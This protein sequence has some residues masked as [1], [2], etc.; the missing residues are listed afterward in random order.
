MAGTVL[1]I[2][3]RGA[4][5]HAPENTLVSIRKA[6]ALGADFVE[7]DVRK[8]RDGGL[9]ILHDASVDRTTNG[10]GQ[11][12]EMGLED[13]RRLDAGG[14]ERIPTLDEI[15]KVAQGRAGLMLEIKSEGIAQQVAATVRESGFAGPILYASFLHSELLPVREIAAG[16]TTMA[17]VETDRQPSPEYLAG[18]R[19]SHVG[20]PFQ[21]LSPQTVGALHREGL[22]VFVYTVNEPSDIE[23]MKSFGVDGI[24][25]DFPERI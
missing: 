18:L 23:R 3:H 15:L 13:L 4:A 14:G 5:G 17:L 21:R 20:W 19:V 11:V 6:I 24:I 22:R 16:A 7:V 12:S 25:S 1:R 8:T 9:V 10:A 2:G